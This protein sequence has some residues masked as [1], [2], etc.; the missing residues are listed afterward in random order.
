VHFVTTDSTTNFLRG[1]LYFNTATD[2][3][4]LQPI[5]TYIRHDILHLLN[6]L[7]WRKK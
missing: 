1:A 7:K 5:I 4:S 3:D 2:N 6:T